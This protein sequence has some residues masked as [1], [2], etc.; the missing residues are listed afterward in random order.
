LVL[1]NIT[2]GWATYLRVSD[3]DKQSPERSFAMQRQRI[4]ENLLSSSKTPFSREYTDLLSGTNP[5]RKDY[6]QLL[7]DAQAGK[8]SHIGLYRADRFG[9]DTVEGLQAAT[10]L[11]SLG[12]KIRIA[13]MPSLRP[14][15]PDGFFMFLI[16]MGMAQ[17]E[18]DVMSQRT[19]DGTEAKIRAGG[20][21]N[22]AP[23]GY[24]N[25]E[26][27][28]KSGKYERW[29][30]PDPK[31]NKPLREAWDLLLTG[32]FTLV[33]V[34]E[35]LARRGYT[36]SNGSPWAWI[37][38]KTAS[39]KT[40]K[41]RLHFIFQ[42]PFYAGW[43]TSEKFN[44]QMGELRGNW[45]PTISTEEYEKGLSILARNGE[46][47]S[48]F[49][50]QHYLLRNVLWMSKEDKRYKMYGSTPTGRKHSY[51]YYITHA[52][53][54]GKKLHLKTQSVDEQVEAWVKGIVIDQEFIPEIRD[55]YRDQI[56]QATEMNS[57][58]TVEQLQ[59]KLVNLQQEEARLVRLQITGEISEET[60][61]Q[62]RLEWKDKVNNI[63]TSIRE[64]DFDTHSHLDDLEIALVLMSKLPVL[65][66][67]LDKKQKTTLLQIVAKKIIIDTQGEIVEH[68]LHS[69]F[70]YLSTLAARISGKSEE[71]YGSEHVPFGSQ[72]IQKPPTDDV[73]RFLAMI[74]FNSKGKLETLPDF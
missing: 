47:K 67:R 36:R 5:N 38:S 42:N 7:T 74:Q 26:R 48:R 43:V 41:G 69:P 56:K 6:Q 28:I 14:E 55:V 70:L 33:Q 59:R 30:E 16:Q 35:E 53:V 39:R 10:K 46:N 31:F 19:R 62:L 29:I 72:D 51:S 49:K 13:S 58:E 52:K 4:Q 15:D 22:K 23:E 60:Y 21:A 57:G 68:E 8:F 9:R 18:V 63:Q 61:K 11:I 3:E 27:Q 32:K 20:W 66:D 71:G 34:C 45:E 2:P 64:L 24:I 54:N 44:I 40:A 65:Y 73:E 12:I 37:D 50:K 17:R 1:Q 25:K